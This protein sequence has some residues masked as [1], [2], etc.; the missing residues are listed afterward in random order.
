M[1]NPGRSRPITS[2]T[3]VVPQNVISKNFLP[4]EMLDTALLQQSVHFFHSSLTDISARSISD[5]G[6]HVVGESFLVFCGCDPHSNSN[7]ILH[8]SASLMFASRAHSKY[9]EL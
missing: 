3:V 6:L 5:L 4:G 1:N 8:S 2:S 7:L 9:A